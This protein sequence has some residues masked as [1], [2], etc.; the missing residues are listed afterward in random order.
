MCISTDAPK[1]SEDGCEDGTRRKLIFTDSNVLNP[2]N[3]IG[4][5]GN[6]FTLCLRSGVLLIFFF[7]Q[8][9]SAKRESL[10]PS[11]KNEREDAPYTIITCRLP[12]KKRFQDS[13]RH[14]RELYSGTVKG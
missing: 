1:P 8:D 5:C 13:S 2:K 12:F 4:K 3:E 11:K 10:L 6:S 14:H 7:F 9:K